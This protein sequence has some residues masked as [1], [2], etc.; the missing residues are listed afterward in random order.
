VTLAQA[1]AVTIG[2]LRSLQSGLDREATDMVQFQI[3]L[4]ED[5]ALTAEALAAVASGA[6]PVAAF[7]E[8][9]ANHLRV[10]EESEDAYLRARGADVCDLRDRVLRA[11]SGACV[12]ARDVTREGAILMV[13]DL[14]P[15]GFLEVDWTRA[16]GAAAINGSPH[17]HVAILARSRGIPMIVGLQGAEQARPGDAC[18]LDADAGLL[19]L[20]PALPTL[21]QYRD[22]AEAASRRTGAERV[23]AHRPAVSRNGRAISVYLNVDAPESLRQGPREWFDGIG[24]VRTELLLDTSRGVPDAATQAA[25]YR[26]LFDWS[27]GR[28]TTIRL[29]DAGGDKPIPGLTLGNEANPFLGMR[30]VRLLLRAPDVLRSQLSAILDAAAGRDVRI[31]IPMIT[32]PQEFAACSTM[33]DAVVAEC[34]ASRATIQLGMMVETPA[35]ALTID[36]FNAQFFSIGTND[37]VQYVMAAGRDQRELQYLQTATA[38]AVLDLIARV[39]QHGISTGKEVGVCGDDAFQP[40]ALRAL[41]RLGISSISV[42]AQ[43]APEVKSLIRTMIAGEA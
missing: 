31:M 27:A 37:L 22:K 30:G 5:P 35:A 9:I 33:L 19:I 4:L 3:E 42:P 25:R 16:T 18:I 13:D 6:D 14:T 28:P 2:Q 7:R 41:L 23:H 40:E 20:Q 12:G 32:V 24:L 11:L 29:W 1:V 17:S 34:G 26:P 39:A 43:R 15:T 36:S 10:Y 38:P 8:G 21:A